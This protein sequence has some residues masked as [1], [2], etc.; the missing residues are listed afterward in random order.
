MR[1]VHSFDPAL[2]G[3]KNAWVAAKKCWGK[4]QT[5]R[6]TN[7]ANDPVVFVLGDLDSDSYVFFTVVPV[8]FL[9]ES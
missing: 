8:A 5:S 6:M 7:L 3:S 1:V 9:S 4:Y 2:D